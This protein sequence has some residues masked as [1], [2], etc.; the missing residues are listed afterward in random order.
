MNQIRTTSKGISIFEKETRFT[1][2]SS[3]DPL[4]YECDLAIFQQLDCR[5]WQHSFKNLNSYL[6]KSG[7][8]DPLKQFFPGSMS[9]QMTIGIIITYSTSRHLTNPKDLAGKLQSM[10]SLIR[11]FPYFLRMDIIIRNR[12]TKHVFCNGSWN[13]NLK[14]IL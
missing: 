2:H 3:T 14:K 4:F 7:K 8:Q 9:P 6:V 1:T 5:S 13:W 11:L 10:L 12:L